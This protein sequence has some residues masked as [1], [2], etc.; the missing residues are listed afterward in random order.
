M[1]AAAFAV[2]MLIGALLAARGAA[3]AAH[4]PQTERLQVMTPPIMVEDVEAAAQES[5]RRRRGVGVEIGAAAYA[6]AAAATVSTAANAAAARATPAAT[7]DPPHRLTTAPARTGIQAGARTLGPYYGDL[8]G[9]GELERAVRLVSS[10][11]DMHPAPQPQ[12]YVRGVAP[13]LPRTVM[14]LR[15]RAARSEQRPLAFAPT[16]PSHVRH[17]HG[18]HTLGPDVPCVPCVPYA[19]CVPCVPCVPTVRTVCTPFPWP[20]R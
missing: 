18:T 13:R 20:P 19:P 11:V 3:V 5:T 8:E 14:H 1:T 12:P 9:Q 16:P 17:A 2:G 4:R 6:T 7:A 10:S 15:R